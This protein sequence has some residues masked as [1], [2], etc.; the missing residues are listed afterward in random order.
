MEQKSGGSV[1]KDKVLRSRGLINNMAALMYYDEY[2]GSDAPPAF[3]KLSADEQK[4]FI[5]A[6]G[7]IMV[8]ADKLGHMIVPKSQ[9]RSDSPLIETEEQR[10]KNI[11]TL[12]GIIR[13]F[14]MK[15]K[16]VKPSLFPC[17]ELAWRILYPKKEEQ[18]EPADNTGKSKDI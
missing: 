7:K 10:N 17:E 8:I 16:V 6:A 2:K 12:T 3:E 11:D 1:S 4:P 18:N 15:L 5:V 9:V 14:I 13:A